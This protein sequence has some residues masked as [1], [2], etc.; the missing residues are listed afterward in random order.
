MFSPNTTRWY[1]ARAGASKGT[2]RRLGAAEARRTTP[3]LPGTSA[4]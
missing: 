2:R 3:N 4:A 1:D